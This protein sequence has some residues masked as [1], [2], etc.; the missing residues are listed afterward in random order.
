M[1]YDVLINY[2]KPDQKI[3]NWYAFSDFKTY[4]S[5]IYKFRREIK[6]IYDFVYVRKHFT[7]KQSGEFTTNFKLITSTGYTFAHFP[8]CDDSTNK[9]L[10]TYFI[11]VCSYYKLT[12]DEIKEVINV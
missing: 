5:V 7:D 10:E 8:K 6:S 9:I 1:T 4:S 11:N 2:C 3:D 12:F